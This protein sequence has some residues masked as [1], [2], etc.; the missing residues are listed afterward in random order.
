M[1]PTTSSLVTHVTSFVFERFCRQP[2]FQGML[3]NPPNDPFDDA[4]QF[5]AKR[6]EE[7]RQ[8]KKQVIYQNES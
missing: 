5:K 8:V 6:E 2:C 4:R 3:N 7:A 1:A